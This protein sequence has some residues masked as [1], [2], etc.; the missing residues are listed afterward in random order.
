MPRPTNLVGAATVAGGV[1]ASLAVLSGA[2]GRMLTWPNEPMAIQLIP[3]FLL[4]LSAATISVLVRALRATG[5]TDDTAACAIE[6]IVLRVTCFLM[7]VHV[8][9]LAALLRADIVSPWA[10]R[11]V[12]VALGVTLTSIGNILPHTRPNPAIGI[13]TSRTL[14]DRHLWMA[15]HRVTGYVTVAIGILTIASG[16]FVSGTAVAALPS[17][18]GIAGTALVTTYYWKTSRDSVTRHV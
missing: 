2:L 1:V 13:R 6:G 5:P 8:L 7:S 16:L 4:P 3:L 14:N 15:T 17:L 18:A 12:V 11:A 10:G 9:L